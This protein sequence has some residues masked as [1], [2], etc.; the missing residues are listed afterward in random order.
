MSERIPTVDTF[1]PI[2][3]KKVKAKSSDNLI[4][5]RSF[6]GVFRTL[7]VGGAAVLF[8]AFFGTVW[9][10]WSGRQAVLWLSLIHI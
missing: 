8:L 4:H 9:L 5:T 10:N 7:R 1:E 2:H 3:P 6:T